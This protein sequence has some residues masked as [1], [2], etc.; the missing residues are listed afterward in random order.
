MFV[1]LRAIVSAMA[2]TSLIGNMSDLAIE[3]RVLCAQVGAVERWEF[4]VAGE[5]FECF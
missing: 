1:S 5:K 3:V 2:Q 4:E